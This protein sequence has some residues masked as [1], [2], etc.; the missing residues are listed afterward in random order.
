MNNINR[1]TDESAPAEHSRDLG[2]VRV[3][4]R[5]LMILRAFTPVNRWLSN[6]DIA[7]AVHLPRP[8]VSRITASLMNL[9]YLDYSEKD[10]RYRLGNSVLALG[11]AAQAN[12]D[13]HV[14]ARP[15]MQALADAQDAMVVLAERDGLAMV[16]SEVCHGNNILSLRVGVGSRLS[17][18]K[19]A[20]GRALIGAMPPPQRAAMLE[21]VRSALGNEWN[22]F[23]R[24]VDDASRQM[25]DKGFYISMGTLE[26]G[27][28]GVGTIVGLRTAPLTYTLGLAGPAFRF[29]WKR[30][31]D[32]IG[33]GLLDIGNRIRQQL[34]G[35]QG[36]D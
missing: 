5:G 16:C 27:V 23:Q 3:L 26:Q 10:G 30:L 12:L 8:T 18:P 2:V 33:P 24:A 28:N 36:P 17:L 21:D 31:E 14:I 32:E 6:Q 25:R 22:D 13:V 9:G 7:A 1:Q 11:F 34:E 29:S 19:S 15:L 20:M 35:E 4:A